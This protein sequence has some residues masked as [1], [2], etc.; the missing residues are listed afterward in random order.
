MEKE[1]FEGNYIIYSDG[2]IWSIKRSKFLK[3]SLH[4]SGYTR[5]CIGINKKTYNIHRL[6]AEA[7][8]PNPNNLPMINHINE[9][10][11]D[12]RVENLE[13]CTNRYNITYS[14]GNKIPGV[15]FFKGKYRVRI[16]INKKHTHIGSFN[17]IEE[18]NQFRLNF[19]SEHNF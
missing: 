18:A 16:Y 7:F 19:I 14:C 10:K 17:T 5:V 3:A 6:V 2:R 12:N 9:I 13:W 11:S 15:H 8:I 4:H 1:I